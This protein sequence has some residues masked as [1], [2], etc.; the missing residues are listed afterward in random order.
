[1]AKLNIN[2]IQVTVP[3]GTRLLDACKKA[4]FNIPTLCYLKDVSSDGSC[5]VCVVEVKGARSLVVACATT[6]RDGMEVITDSPAV[7][8]ARKMTLELLISNHNSDCL[9]CSRS[10]NCDLQKLSLEYGCDQNAYA[11][12][13][14]KFDIDDQNAFIVRDY[15]KCI[16][17]RRCSNV[18]KVVQDVGV[19]TAVGRG[20]TTHIGCAFDVELGESP[21]VACGQC[22]AVCPTAALKEKTNISQVVDAVN[23]ASKHVIVATAPAV[24]VGLGDEFGMKTGDFVEG[25]MVAGLRRLGFD[26]VFDINFSADLTIMEEG[27]EFLDRLNNNSGPLPMVT[28]CSPGWVRYVEFYAPEFIDNLSTCKSPQQMFGA[29]AKTYYAEKNGINP[30]DIVVV[31]IMPCTAKKYEITREYQAASGYPDVD[32]VLT[33]KELARLIKMKGIDFESLPKESFDDLLGT[34]S[35]AGLIFGTSGGVMEAA[36]RTISEVVLNKPLNNLDFKNIRG[37]KGV[38]EAEIKLGDKTV[39]VAVVSGIANAKKVL[40][41]VKSGKKKYHFIEMMACPGGCVNGGGQPVKSVQNRA[42]TAGTRGKS[43]YKAD[44]ASGLRKSHENPA[45]KTLYKDYLGKPGGDKA[46]KLLHT[47]YAKSDKF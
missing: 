24:R 8:E 37:T 23:D 30:K 45:I 29:I 22:V 21:C 42:E 7:I 34:G 1:M 41:D 44:K 20:F 43:M 32:Y 36:L 33:T 25:K 18:C 27:H 12:C 5:R 19:V 26:K 28:S 31:T 40:A 14:T 16:L 35:T 47:K 46:H 6:V 10:Q 17:C 39:K 3:D 15:N 4:G 2:G 38:K 9:S 13:K 11:G